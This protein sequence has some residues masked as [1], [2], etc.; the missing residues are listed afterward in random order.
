MTTLF[1]ENQAWMNGVADFVEPL[2]FDRYASCGPADLLPG[3]ELMRERIVSFIRA[4]D[5]R[6]DGTG[7]DDSYHGARHDLVM[8]L[9]GDLR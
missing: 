3:L 8:A 1:R 4:A 2:G 5:A 7:D 9:G 6:A